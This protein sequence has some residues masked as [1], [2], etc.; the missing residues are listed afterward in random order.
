LYVTAAD[1]TVDV[2]YDLNNFA[3][4]AAI[5]NDGSSAATHLAYMTAASMPA[6]NYAVA[7]GTSLASGCFTF[8]SEPHNTVTGPA[9]DAAITGI[10][11]FVTNGGNFLAQCEG[12]LNY[13]NNPLGRFQTTTGVTLANVAIGT[14]LTYPNG[15]LS[16]SQFEGIYNGSSGG[17]VRNWTIPGAGI[18]NEHLHGFRTSGSI[19]VAAS[20]SKLKAGIGGLVF[21]IGNHGFST[22]TIDG[23][24]GIRMYMNAFLTPA[25]TCPTVLDDRK[26]V[27]KG[28][29]NVNFINLDWTASDNRSI[30]YFELEQSD[31][32]SVFTRVAIIPATQKRGKE[33]Y[34]Y[35]I[36]NENQDNKFYRVKTVYRNSIYQYGNVISISSNI[37]SMTNRFTLLQNPVTATIGLILESKRDGMNEFSLYDLT[38]RKVHA[39]NIKYVKG[40]NQVTVHLTPGLHSGVYT[41]RVTDKSEVAVFKIV[42]L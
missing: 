28:K 40:V 26:V 12:V 2:R 35:N 8:A 18:N 30:D 27:L 13:E 20:V 14:T 1:V 4:K 31:D 10:R 6:A 37:N 29:A 33:S 34:L 7:N 21:Y 36:P 15:D 19:Y 23:V 32:A 11:N 16:F 17:T 3:P 39:E 42:K 41:L 22:I 5:L 9:V 25:V 38:G 24:N